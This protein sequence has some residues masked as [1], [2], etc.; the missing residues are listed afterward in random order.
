MSAKMP[1]NAAWSKMTREKP[2]LME[3]SC[4]LHQ[5]RAGPVYAA[6]LIANPLKL[7]GDAWV[8]PQIKKK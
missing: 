1:I 6:F 8:S 7:V 2:T 4:P 3:F 5:R